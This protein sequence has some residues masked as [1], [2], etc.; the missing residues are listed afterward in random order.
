M[1]FGDVNVP[2][3]LC[4]SLSRGELVVFA[5]A[6]VSMSPP[7]NLPSFP[8][9]VRDV[10]GN[11]PRKDAALDRLL[12]DAA[13]RNQDVHRRVHRRIEATT[14]PNA[15]HRALIELSL[16]PDD[17]RIVTT[18]YD[19]LFE[20]ALK[21]KGWEVPCHAAPALPLGDDFRGVVHL[22]GMLGD[23]ADRLVVTDSDF[24]RAYITEGWARR[25]L[26]QLFKSFDVLFVGYSYGDLVVSYL[27]RGLPA[28]LKTRRFALVA[29][30]TES[31]AEFAEESLHQK[32]KC[33]GVVPCVYPRQSAEEG[34][35]HGCLTECVRG[36]GRFRRRG[37][38]EIRERVVRI[39]QELE[40]A[41]ERKGSVGP[42]RH[43]PEYAFLLSVLNRPMEAQF[44]FREAKAFFWVEWLEEEGL[45]EPVFSNEADEKHEYLIGWFG[46]LAALEP[47]KFLRFLPQTPGIGRRIHLTRPLAR[48]LLA[49]LRSAP[50]ETFEMLLALVI[51]AGVLDEM[52][53][54]PP[55]WLL[56]HAIENGLIEAA[57]SIVCA[58]LR[59]RYGL[60]SRFRDGV[61]TET[62][63][64]VDTGRRDR[65]WDDAIEKLLE[66]LTVAQRDVLLQHVLLNLRNFEREFCGLDPNFLS[67]KRPSVPAHEQ[68]RSYALDHLVDFAVSLVGQMAAEQLSLGEVESWLKS[69][70]VLVQRVALYTLRCMPNVRA[71]RKLG[72]VLEREWLFDVARRCEV[73]NLVRDAFWGAG[74]TARRE[75]LRAIRQFQSNDLEDRTIAYQ[76]FNLLSWLALGSEDSDEGLDRLLNK[77][78]SR[79]PEFEVRAYPELNGYSYAG[80]EES[81][82]PARPV[83]ELLGLSSEEHIG[84]LRCE[85]GDGDLRLHGEELRESPERTVELLEAVDFEAESDLPVLRALASAID[86]ADLSPELC[87][88]VYGVLD[89][90]ELTGDETSQQIAR[91]ARV[92]AF[93][94]ELPRELVAGLVD[95]LGTHTEAEREPFSTDAYVAALNTTLGV[96][97]ESL[98][99][100]L[101]FMA[102]SEEPGDTE[103]GR[104]LEV[105]S[106]LLECRHQSRRAV[107]AMLMSYAP[108]LLEVAPVWMDE[109]VLP[110]L[111]FETDVEF[112]VAAWEG[113]GYVSFVSDELYHHC[114]EYYL[115]LLGELDRFDERQQGMYLSQLAIFWIH[116][117]PDPIRELVDPLWTIL[118]EEEIVRFLGCLRTAISRLEADS[119]LRQWEEWLAEFWE[120]RCSQTPIPLSAR[121]A[122]ALVN[123]ALLSSEMLSEVGE[124]L[125]DLPVAPDLQEVEFHVLRD[126]S[127]GIATEFPELT[128]A[129]LTRITTIATLPWD[130]R[131]MGFIHLGEI[132]KEMVEVCPHD[133]N[134]PILFQSLEGLGW[135]EVASVRLMHEEKKS[136]K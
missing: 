43:H 74:V 9:L 54:L 95:I 24:S 135:D 21:E 108:K 26:V 27:A 5:G 129:F 82:A 120:L 38:L 20:A 122:A 114:V 48:A 133:A 67:F 30:E 88:R 73:F 62:V 6:G 116:S 112:A 63:A 121:E 72:F 18:N 106:A 75:L 37:T 113:L 92:L 98:V 124:V 28:D 87:Q 34:D 31:E 96:V 107:V 109:Q 44:F 47:L 55:S 126:W 65:E 128:M 68:N 83:Q 59:P 57:L 8:G 36:L 105:L 53:L 99:G 97:V 39:V 76:Q 4:D 91:I 17:V 10:T 35:T 104:V 32:W 103:R 12:G 100:L 64:R 130:H 71:S 41:A 131:T 81:E 16:S 132:V 23:R 78:H 136:R 125:C 45:L 66:V 70:S 42:V 102:A 3:E 11:T 123:I 69:D 49:C 46:A 101:F 56:N 50:T 40:E 84:W 60:S 134:W 117:E 93:S 127:D 115:G 19:L 1:R 2:R 90:H 58:T 111:S 13:R 33:L 7:S 85:A 79:Y 86:V 51:D 22:H 110:N 80:H 94:A 15:N 14:L 118:S 52:A 119:Q 25:F 89:A 61:R 77:V 29:E